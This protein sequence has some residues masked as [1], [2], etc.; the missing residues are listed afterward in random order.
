MTTMCA[1]DQDKAVESVE[2]QLAR[3]FEPCP[4]CRKAREALAAFNAESRGVKV[5]ASILDPEDGEVTAKGKDVAQMQVQCD[6]CHNTEVV[7]SKHGQRLLN[8][9]ATFLASHGR[10]LRTGEQD[11]PF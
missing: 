10:A 3:L 2:R 8:F 7:P 6:E 9:V 11:I 4:R 5:L 1:N